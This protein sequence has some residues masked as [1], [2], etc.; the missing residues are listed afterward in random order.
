[1]LTKVKN[2]TVTGNNITSND[3]KKEEIDKIGKEKDIDQK[4]AENI[5]PFA[6]ENIKKGLKIKLMQIT[7]P[8]NRHRDN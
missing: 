1:M 7:Y 8:K 2:H 3:N 4:P 6:N 5:D